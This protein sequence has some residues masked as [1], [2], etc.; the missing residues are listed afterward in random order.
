MYE[1]L[2][3]TGELAVRVKGKDLPSLFISAAAAMNDYLLQDLTPGAEQGTETIE[4]S[5]A[6][7][8]SLLVAWLSEILYRIEVNDCI[9]QKFE[10]KVLEKTALIAEIT[11]AR[12]RKLA[13]DIK[14]ATHH[15]LE[16]KRIP[17]GYEVVIIFDI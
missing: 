11:G 2:E 12:V 6:D 15:G 5:A 14:A 3:H 1:F 8:R 10:V 9:Y 17:D 13:R 7:Y 16:I 4:V